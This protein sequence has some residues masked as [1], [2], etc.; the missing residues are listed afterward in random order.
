MLVLLARKRLSVSPEME[1]SRTLW[2]VR[3]F[4]IAATRS[5]NSEA[6]CEPNSPRSM[7]RRTFIAFPAIPVTVYI[8]LDASN[9]SLEYR[10]SRLYE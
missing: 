10:G 8:V 6:G 7:W 2:R 4:L 3:T 1:R 9:V 5:C